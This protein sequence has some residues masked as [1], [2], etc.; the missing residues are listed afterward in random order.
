LVRP[1]LIRKDGL[2]VNSRG[3]IDRVGDSFRAAIGPGVL[4]RPRIAGRAVA[5][6]RPGVAIEFVL[7]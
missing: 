1:K 3:Q 4:R 6:L 5:A 2:W 7:D